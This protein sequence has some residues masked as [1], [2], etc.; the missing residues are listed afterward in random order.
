[1]FRVA[2]V[3]LDKPHVPVVIVDFLREELGHLRFKT[4]VACVHT[5]PTDSV[6]LGIEKPKPLRILRPAI[7]DRYRQERRPLPSRTFLAPAR[8]SSQTRRISSELGVQCVRML[9]QPRQELTKKTLLTTLSTIMVEAPRYWSYLVPLLGKA[10]ARK[11]GRA[12]SPSSP[13]RAA[14]SRPL[15]TFWNHNTENYTFVSQTDRN[16]PVYPHRSVVLCVSCF[17]LEQLAHP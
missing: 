1:M 17:H 6:S 11:A 12:A 5:T 9:R 3:V 14:T 4:S 16:A 2:V 7:K 13:S 10:E 15:P 8:V